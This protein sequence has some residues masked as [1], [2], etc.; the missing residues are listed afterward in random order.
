MRVATR[1][2]PNLSLEPNTFKPL[3]RTPKPLP[4]CVT[5]RRV[6][7]SWILPQS[8]EGPES[9]CKF[10][11]GW[12]S[13]VWQLSVPGD[14]V[15]VGS[16]FGILNGAQTNWRS[17]PSLLLSASAKTQAERTNKI[18]IKM[19]LNFGSP[20]NKLNCVVSHYAHTHAPHREAQTCA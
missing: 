10:L 19:F 6:Q 13:N 15:V 14:I 2:K 8:E 1:W 16:A 3:S 17:L 4:L 7:C 20:C 9:F 18:K 12:A 11:L 5:T